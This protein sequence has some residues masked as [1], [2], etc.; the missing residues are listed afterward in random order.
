MTLIVAEESLVS[1]AQAGDMGAFGELYARH[2]G[3]VHNFFERRQPDETAADDLS[4]EVFVKAMQA[5][6]GYTW[7]GVPI[8]AWLFRIARHLLVDGLRRRTRRGVDEALPEAEALPD[9][10]VFLDP[11]R[12]VVAKE[13]R[14]ALIAAVEALPPGQRTS[15][16]L[17]YA[18]GLS[19]AEAGRMLGKT[20]EAVSRSR[21]QGVRT[22]RRQLVAG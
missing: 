15:I 18:R 4:Q 5:L 20:E 11:A 22:L 9:P 3:E 2:V 7:T 19:C 17:T 16:T 12:W 10:D 21:F 6:A 8:R 14:L 13:T 1:A